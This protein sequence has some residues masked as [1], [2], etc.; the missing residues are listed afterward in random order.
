MS[1]CIIFSDYEDRIL[2][3]T[4]IMG[5]LLRGIH[6]LLNNSKYNDKYIHNKCRDFAEMGIKS[7]E[8]I[9][10]INA[11]LREEVRNGTKCCTCNTDNLVD[12]SELLDLINRGVQQRHSVQNDQARWH[13]HCSSECQ[14]AK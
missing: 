12:F 11:E 6:K 4:A 1:K 14:A 2:Q 3:Q 5:M 8:K 13:N 9:D 7:A 10:G